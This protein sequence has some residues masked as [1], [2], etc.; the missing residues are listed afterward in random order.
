MYIL[1]IPKRMQQR[2]HSTEE[3]KSEFESYASL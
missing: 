2:H 3:Q 1:Q